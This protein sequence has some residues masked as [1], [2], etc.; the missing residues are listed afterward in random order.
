MTR[1]TNRKKG[2]TLPMSAINGGNDHGSIPDDMVWDPENPPKVNE[3][4]GTERHL[5]GC[6][7]DCGELS[8]TESD[9]KLFNEK[10]AWAR[11]DMNLFMIPLGFDMLGIGG[12][13][14]DL[15][16]MEAKLHGIVDVLVESGLVSVED[17]NEA[18]K[19]RMLEKM[20]KVRILNADAIQKARTA[21][22]L[23]INP[24]R[25]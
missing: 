8:L 15:L 6:D 11:L 1:P 23:G 9:V 2:R 4:T 5:P 3:C 21:S 16:E 17:I 20:T 12:M 22:M 7:G 13:P 14:I 25:L 24:N 19:T 10:L 18:L